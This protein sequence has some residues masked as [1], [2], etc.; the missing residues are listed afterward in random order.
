M[1]G[2]GLGSPLE[3]KLDTT[4]VGLPLARLLVSVDRGRVTERERIALIRAHRRQVS[5]YQAASYTEMNRHF[6]E[7]VEVLEGD[8]EVA[9][10]QAQLEIGT[11]LRYTRRKASDEIG[12]AFQ[13]ATHPRVARALQLGTTDLARARVILDHLLLL[14]ADHADTVLD[15]V[16][17]MAPTLTTGQLAALLRRLVD[18]YDPRAAKKA[19]QESLELRAIEVKAEPDGTATLTG[20]HLPADQA[21]AVYQRITELAADLKAEGDLRTLDQIRADLVLDLLNGHEQPAGK[22][23]VV[24]HVDLA[25]LTELSQNPGELNGYGPV[26]ADIARQIAENQTN[27]P[28]SYIVTDPSTDQTHCTGTTRRRPRR[29]LRQALRLL[30]PTCTF[31]GCRQPAERTDTDHLTPYSR[32]GE[33]KATNLAPLCRY[34]NRTKHLVGW[35]VFRL[36]KTTLQWTSPLGLIYHTGADPP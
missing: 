36:D 22:G 32:G 5:H 7:L 15:Q 8:T 18:S 11:A 14:D 31:P 9:Y 1:F 12:V 29:S 35:T 21:Q 27:N 23:E 4:Q 16:M 24:L 33:T 19:Y 34:H 20:Y 6:E 26:I 10:E 30:H 2:D 3:E 28:W 25:T 17:P 13:L